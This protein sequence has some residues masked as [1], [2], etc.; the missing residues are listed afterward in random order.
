TINNV[1]PQFDAGPDEVLTPVQAGAFSRLAIPFTDPGV[2]TWTGTVDFGDGSGVQALSVDQV[3]HKFSLNH[4]YTAEG[5]FP[6]TVSVSD[7]DPGG[8]TTDGF[9]VEVH[10]F[11]T[12]TVTVA[13]S[14]DP[15]VYGQGVTFTA[16]VSPAAGPGTP[17]GSVAFYDGANLLDTEPL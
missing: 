10:L 13:S 14:A 16:T 7:G 12:P 6:V 1:P 15:S 17:A 5:T 3:T 4:T 2:D 9:H 11:S 8:T